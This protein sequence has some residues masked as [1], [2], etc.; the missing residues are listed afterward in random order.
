MVESQEISL[1]NSLVIKAKAK[2]YLQKNKKDNR[3]IFEDSFYEFVKE[4]WQHIDPDPF[5]DGWHAKSICDHCQAM[6]E[7]VF[8]DES[9]ILII[10]IPPGFG[11]SLII[12]VMFPVWLWIKDSSLRQLTGSRASDVMVRDTVKSRD[13]MRSDWFQRLWGNEI[14]LSH[15]QNQKT[16]Y[17]NENLGVRVG[18]TT[19]GSITGVRCNYLG[20]DDPNDAKGEDTKTE[21][22]NVNRNFG[23]ALYT[24]LNNSSK[25]RK[26]VIVV[27][28]RLAIDDLSGYLL[29]GHKCI[30]LFLQMEFEPN[31]RCMTKIFADPRTEKDEL[32]CEKIK[33]REEV[34]RLKILLGSMGTAGQLQ[35]RPFPAEGNVFKEVWFSNRFLFKDLPRLDSI[36]LSLDTG[37]KEGQENDFHSLNVW[38][39]RGNT[40][41]M[42]DIWRDKCGF[43]A[44][45]NKCIEMY[46]RYCN[47][48]RHC[49]V[50]VLLIEEKAAGVDIVSVLKEETML[51]IEAIIPQNS[52]VVRANAITPMLEN[53]NVFFPENSEREWM[54]PY[55]D[56][57]LAFP[58]KTG[59]DDQ[60]DSTTQALNYIRTHK[61]DEWLYL[62]K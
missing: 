55:L 8:A 28:Q 40:I 5:I 7:G 60:V 56:E 24:R 33:N 13:L 32:L 46:V 6:F 58:S 53:G 48:Q 57:M 9:D 16:N 19:S 34:D 23:R 37:W 1:P 38:G 51:N 54:A 43:N 12:S 47:Y 44:L 52:K 30:H 2:L 41:Y 17:K 59:H 25:T 10:N 14:I 35:Q 45:K 36:V 15:D 11:K 20:L 3:A 49:R 18:F 4:A 26:F 31:N 61:I 62:C 50:D 29:K 22:D 42:L 39:I 27:M 21:Y